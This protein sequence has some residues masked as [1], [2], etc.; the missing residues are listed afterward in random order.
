VLEE[1]LVAI[2]PDPAAVENRNADIQQTSLEVENAF[3]FCA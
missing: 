2:E 1:V 3:N